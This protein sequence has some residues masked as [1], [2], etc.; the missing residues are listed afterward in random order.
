V[1]E[2]KFVNQSQIEPIAQYRNKVFAKNPKFRNSISLQP[3][4]VNLCYLKL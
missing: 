4:S 3:D 2:G 1:R